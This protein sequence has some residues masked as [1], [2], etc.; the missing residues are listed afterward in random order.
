MSSFLR[1][2]DT[3]KPTDR[4]FLRPDQTQTNIV[5]H[6]AIEQLFGDIRKQHR[7]KAELRHERTAY[8]V[9][10]DARR[11]EYDDRI[12]RCEY[13]IQSCQDQFAQRLEE[14][15]QEFSDIMD[16]KTERNMITIVFRDA[17]REITDVRVR[18]R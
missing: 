1:S 18:E 4:D 13:L 9:E 5:Q 15:A 12:E 6:K 8:D 16:V 7:A 2:I 3:G 10:V 14:L 11:Q 17:S